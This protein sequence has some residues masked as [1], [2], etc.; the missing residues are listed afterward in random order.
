MTS[1]I[2][3]KEALL[4]GK[5]VGFTN[6]SHFASEIIDNEIKKRFKPEFVN[7]IDNIIMFN[8]L[9]NDDLLKIIELELNDLHDRV[10]KI[11]FEFKSDFISLASDY[12][13]NELMEEKNSENYGARPVVRLIR[14]DIENRITEFIINEDP[15]KGYEISFEE[16]MEY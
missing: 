1:N 8:K 4:R 3:T 15:P 16:I 14:N 11:D 10:S 5:G 13:F 9:N 12:I 7:R 6:S 2:G